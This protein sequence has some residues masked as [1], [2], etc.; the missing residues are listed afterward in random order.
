MDRTKAGV[1]E[2]TV[3][4][5]I[6]A[7]LF[8]LKMWASIITGSIALAAD[9]WHT[10]SD[11]LTSIIVVIASKLA[12]KKADAKHP[13]GHGR[14]VLLASLFMGIVLGAIGYDFLE[15]SIIKFKNKE[16][17]EFGIIAII[18]I[19]ISIIV[20][21]LLAQ[22]AFYL[23]KKTDNAS[24]IADGWHHRSDSL[25]SV[26]VLIGVL[27]AKQFWWIDSVLGI[28]CALVLFYVT[29]IIMKE[30]ITKIL[31]ETPCPKLITQITNEV[32]SAYRD[33]FDMH[34]FHIHDYIAHKEL[35]FHIRLKKNLT[36]EKGHTIA[37]NIETIIKDKFDMEA[38]IHI[39]PS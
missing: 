36:I 34:H 27:F 20:K 6:N 15:N 14:W 5:I 9:A 17:A 23:G 19:I 13:F 30:S 39:D 35:T 12:S 11:S 16:S 7:V 38:T 25:S 28:F 3:S 4:I 31:G 8:G 22:Y 37:T 33:D 18:V 29:F 24:V 32:K 21:E 10:L 26:I 1:V 2:G